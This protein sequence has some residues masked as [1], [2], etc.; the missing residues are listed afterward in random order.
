MWFRGCISES[1]DDRK[2]S[3]KVFLDNSLRDNELLYM[4]EKNFEKIL[5]KVQ[6]KF[7][8]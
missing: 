3:K 4:R 1:G 8:V 5:K 7:G 2:M 6:E